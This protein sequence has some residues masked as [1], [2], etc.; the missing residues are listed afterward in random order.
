MDHL[1]SPIHNHHHQSNNCIPS[2]LQPI[3]ASYWPFQLVL[4]AIAHRQSQ[5]TVMI[6]QSNKPSDAPPEVTPNDQHNTGV[7]ESI[8]AL[9]EN[10][11]SVADW[12]NLVE[13]GYH[14]HGDNHLMASKLKNLD[15]PLEEGIC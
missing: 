5:S 11:L 10:F 12:V 13:N 14:G 2:K 1:L 8:S 6:V 9:E 7:D 15:T 3:G 4:H